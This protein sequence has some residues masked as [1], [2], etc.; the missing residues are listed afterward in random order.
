MTYLQP[1]TMIDE[2]PPIVQL[3]AKSI[4][5]DPRNNM[6]AGSDSI[7]YEEIVKDH[8]NIQSKIRKTDPNPFGKYE[9]TMGDYSQP[10]VVYH[11][12]EILYESPRDYQHY[13]PSNMFP[14]PNYY[15]MNQQYGGQRYGI[16]Q[17]GNH[18]PQYPPP[19]Y[20]SHYYPPPPTPPSQQ[21]YPSPSP[22]Q[23]K[24][25][26]EKP[27]RTTPGPIVY[28]NKSSEPGV[29]HSD[30]V[31]GSM[32]PEERDQHLAVSQKRNVKYNKPMVDTDT[33]PVVENY[34]ISCK[35]VMEHI[36][37]CPVCTRLYRRNDRIYFGII[38]VLLF[39]IFIL[40]WK[41]K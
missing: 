4:N 41:R 7:Y 31:P 30:Y 11:Q 23:K 39:L 35:D 6:N 17:Y 16:Q 15:P 5:M 27:A 9:E 40:L 29:V 3:P 19:Q 32:V 36:D 13:P 24:S 37:N 20:P 25:P 18:L 8:P 10:K 12:E 22:V 21:Y 26:M 28:Q 2:L 1:F 38:G 34:D 14:L 33:Y